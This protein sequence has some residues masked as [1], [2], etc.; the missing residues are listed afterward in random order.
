MRQMRGPLFPKRTQMLPEPRR[1]P[2]DAAPQG[3]GPKG[4]TKGKGKGVDNAAK[5]GG[6]GGWPSLLAS[7]KARAKP[8]AKA[9][10]TPAPWAAAASQDAHDALFVDK[11]RLQSDPVYAA[12]LRVVLEKKLE[13]PD[14]LARA[15]EQLELD[16]AR[17]EADLP[18]ERRLTAL[19]KRLR[20]AEAGEAKYITRV[21]SIQQEID[22]ASDRLHEAK[23]GLKSQQARV[24]SIK[25]DIEATE[26]LVPPVATRAPQQPGL[27]TPPPRPPLQLDELQ[28]L[29][30]QHFQDKYRLSEESAHSLES[31][32]RGIEALQDNLNC[33]NA[34]NEAKAN[35]E[36]RVQTS[37]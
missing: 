3:P 17:H 7:A 1:P 23:L 18:P 26:L 22:A 32:L 27:V 11:R 8:R 10:P 9:A 34:V 12:T 14:A 37:K 30:Y 2:R 20:A 29:T 15:E 24:A 36:L 16:R 28:E 4:P 5:G 35:D 21:D 6:K 33:V 25:A 19:R 13:Q 31:Q